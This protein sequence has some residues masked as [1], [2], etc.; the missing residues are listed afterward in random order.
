M[1]FDDKKFQRCNLYSLDLNETVAHGGT[2]KIRFQRIA[3]SKSLSGACNFVDFTRMPPG[4]TIGEHS[5]TTDEEEFYLIL[6]G[7]GRM[8]QGGQEFD[9]GPGD[10][11]RNA[12]GGTHSLAN[13]GS[14]EL[15]LFVFEV[16]VV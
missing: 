5:H 15:Q 7:Q 3:N 12:P 1:G 14:E 6:R 9:V 4:S 11:I 13:T 16:K 2:G 10:L 8:R